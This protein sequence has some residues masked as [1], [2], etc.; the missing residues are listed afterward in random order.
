MTLKVEAA[1]S[2]GAMDQIR[3][4]VDGLDHLAYQMEQKWGV[5]RLRLL[6]SNDLRVRFDQQAVRFDQALWD[7]GSVWVIEAEATR[8]QSA[9]LTLDQVATQGGCQP[10]LPEVWEFPLENGRVGAI[11]RTNAEAALV[12]RAGRHLV[13]YTVAE[14]G[15]ILDA[16]GNAVVNAVKQEFPGAEIVRTH[17][18]RAVMEIFQ[19]DAIDDLFMGG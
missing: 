6:V 13:V 1:T 9:W 7:Q 3:A 19:D 5:G 16:R 15:R 10:L 11:T 18:D 17:G 12:T 8:M 14:I 2:Q 4:I